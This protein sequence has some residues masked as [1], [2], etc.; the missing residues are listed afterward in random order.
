MSTANILIVEDEPAIVE[1]IAINLKHAGFLYQVATDV[2]QAKDYVRHT[3]PDLVL[4]DWMLPDESGVALTRYWRMQERTKL[5]P[6][7]L[8]TARGA[9]QDIVEG[10]NAGADDY[11]VKPFSTQEML[12]RIRALLRRKLPEAGQ[13]T[14]HAGNLML[15]QTEHKVHWN[16]EIIH[17]GATEFKLLNY[18]M[19]HPNRVLS[20][21][22]ILDKV[23]GDHVFIEERTVDV[24]IKRLRMVLDNAG[25]PQLIETVRGAGYEFKQKG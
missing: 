15:S 11:M 21:T 10:L 22:Q 13:E 16:D 12:A 19:C 9:D 14:I 23:W 25:V 1:L 3:L 5:L 17:M 24:H 18:L 6:I 7:M 8:I 2:A 20:R 4:L